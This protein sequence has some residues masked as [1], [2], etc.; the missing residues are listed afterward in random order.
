MTFSISCPLTYP[1]LSR[2]IVRSSHR[3]SCGSPRMV[4]A[5]FELC[6]QASQ[7]YNVTD[8]VHVP[9]QSSILYILSVFLYTLQVPYFPSDLFKMR[10]LVLSLFGLYQ[11]GISSRIEETSDSE[12]L[13]IDQMKREIAD[14]E[15][16]IKSSF[17]LS[18]DPPI[19]N[20]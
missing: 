10:L 20:N 9:E 13:L 19:W 7:S 4:S 17:G 14:R 15:Q 5:L 11:P 8:L 2:N 16:G 1:S 3:T 18:S 6:F 12:G